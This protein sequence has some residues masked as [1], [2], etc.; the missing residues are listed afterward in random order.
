SRSAS[1]STGEFENNFTKCRRGDTSSN[2]ASQ[3]RAT[4]ASKN[5]ARRKVDEVGRDAVVA[6]AVEV[7]VRIGPR[8]HGVQV[9]VND[10]SDVECAEQLE[11]RG[12]LEARHPR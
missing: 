12:E 10:D 3:H 6:D 9:P 5:A 1:F 11:Y 8:R 4:D 7:A 2:R